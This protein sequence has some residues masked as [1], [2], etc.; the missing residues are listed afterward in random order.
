L[1]QRRRGAEENNNV[2]YLVS[3]L[4]VVM[5]LGCSD[6]P[7][8]APDAQDGGRHADAVEESADVD[9]GPPP[10]TSDDDHWVIRNA[11]IVDHRGARQVAAIEIRNGQIVSVG[12]PPGESLPTLE[13]DGRYVVPGLVDPHVHLNL[14]GAT[15]FVGDALETNLRANLYWGVTGVMDMGGPEVLFELREAAR[16][17]E[18]LAPRMR[19]TGPFL[20]LPEAHPCEV[21]NDQR[22]CEF[23]TE[24]TI[25]GSAQHLIRKGADAIKV[26]LADTSMLPGD[27]PRMDPAWLDE[28]DGLD[29]PVAAH[30]NSPRDLRQSVDRGVEILAHPTFSARLDAATAGRATEAEMVHTTVSA[31][32]SVVDLVE[33]GIELDGEDLIVA[34]GVHANWQA[35]ADDPGLLRDGWV[36]ASRGWADNA[37]H[38]VGALREAEAEVIPASDAGYFFVPHGLGLHRELAYLAEEGW[39]YERLLEA[40]TLDAR[41]QLDMPGGTVAEG[42]PADLVVVADNPLDDIRHL[43]QVDRVVRAGRVYSR[44]ELLQTDLSPGRDAESGAACLNRADCADGLRCDP[45]NHVCRSACRLAYAVE[46][47]CGPE[48]WCYPASQQSGESRGVCHPVRTCDDEDDCRPSAYG[49]NCRPLDADTNGC[50][51]SGTKGVG[52]SCQINLPGEAC[53]N[54]LYCSPIDSTCYRMCEPGAAMSMCGPGTSCQWQET[55]GGEEWFGLCL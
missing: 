6:V 21:V 39:S 4:V 46:N 53:R 35:I 47:D 33:G 37:R 18:L 50:V 19:L 7:E 36:E 28:L 1:P 22:Q 2:K 41:R 40:V 48:A 9:A 23:V 30:I 52:E 8:P 38:N 20:T 13:A 32:Q 14:S 5:G 31:F 25:G 43:R 3:I 49:E 10:V 55:P 45:L 51:A 16:D 11:T 42:E 27:N 24:E 34:D 44:P 26:S 17:G 15:T 29:A 12:E 54:G